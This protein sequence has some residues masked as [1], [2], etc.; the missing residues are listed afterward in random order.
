MTSNAGENRRTVLT[1]AAA[2]VGASALEAALSPTMGQVGASVAIPY[3][4]AVQEDLLNADPRYLAAVKSNCQMIVAEGAMKMGGIQPQR[5]KF[6]FQGGDNLVAF[7]HANGMQIRG[8]TLVWYAANPEWVKE[9]STP[10][11]AERELVRHIEGVV[12][13]F[14]GR[15]KSWDVVNEPIAEEPAH[16]RDLRRS[17]WLQHLGP[18]YLEIALRTAAAVDPGLQL[19]INE[20]NI[21]TNDKVQRRRRDTILTLLRDL[22]QKGVPLGA[23]GFQGHLHGHLPIDKDAVSQLVADVKALGLDVLVTELDVIDN[24]LAADPAQRDVAIASRVSD[25]LGAIAAAAR[26]TAVLTW[27]ITDRYTWVPMYF[28]RADG[29]RNRP[30]P[31]DAEYVRKPMMRVV[32]DFCRSGA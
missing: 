4:V 20:F 26:P 19:V 21:E 23:L 15:I 22:K 29:S 2:L 8:H 14:K 31:L 16:N 11:E 5:G 12:S 28:K 30:L 10:L 27:G 13:H 17:V 32:Q 7:A 18:R 24:Q 3:G 1:G 6:A 9:I 25:F